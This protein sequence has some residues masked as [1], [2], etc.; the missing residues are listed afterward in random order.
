M[1]IGV[2]I[3]VYGGDNLGHFREAID[4]IKS[5]AINNELRINIYLHIDGDI[6]IE[7]NNYIN[8]EG[9]FCV[10]GSSPNVGLAVGLNK[11]VKKIGSEEFIFRMDADD[12]VVPGRFQCQ[13]RFMRRNPQVDISGGSIGEFLGDKSNVVNVRKYPLDNVNIQ[14]TLFRASPLAHVTVCFRKGYFDRF[15]DYPTTSPLNEDI[16][17]W[18]KSSNRN[19]IFGNVSDVLVNVRMDGAYDRR[20]STKAF[21]E[22]KLYLFHNI[23]NLKIPIVPFFRLLFRYFPRALVEI[24]YNSPIRKMFT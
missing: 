18:M 14:K 2:L 1:D 17:Y 19:A 22:F 10:I 13:L 7:M 12:V 6:P 23:K 5:E 11:L 16:A 8:S 24:I 15:G 4:S 9:L 20:R 21:P 3:C